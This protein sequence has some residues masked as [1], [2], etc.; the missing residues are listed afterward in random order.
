MPVSLLWL[1]LLPVTV[2]ALVLLTKIP[3]DEVRVTENPLIVTY[4]LPDTRNPFAP[5]VTVTVAPGAAWNTIGAPARP[6]RATVTF[7]GYV[8]AATSTVCPAVATAAALPIVQYGCAWLFGP[9]SEQFAP[10]T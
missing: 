2:E 5:P 3:Y 7:S 10:P 4:C 6:D 1:V 8:P 9:A